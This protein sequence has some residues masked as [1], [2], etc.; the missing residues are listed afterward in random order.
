MSAYE[1]IANECSFAQRVLIKSEVYSNELYSTY[2]FTLVLDNGNTFRHV[3]YGHYLDSEIDNDD[4]AT[5]RACSY[6]TVKD[7][8]SSLGFMFDSEKS[9]AFELGECDDIRI[10]K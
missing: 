3:Y 10:E 8:L 1:T 4:L 2:T 6:K 5:Q 9:N 7:A